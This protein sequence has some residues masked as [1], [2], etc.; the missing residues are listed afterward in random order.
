MGRKRGGAPKG[1][2]NSTAEHRIVSNQLMK[3]L[4]QDALKGKR[5]K[6]RK[7]LEK[8]LTL[9]EGGDR[10][11]LEFIAD[12]SEGKPTQPTQHTGNV[13]VTLSG[14]DADL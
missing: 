3:V 12:R 7:A 4:K 6:V 9:A 5:S 14:S 11:A 10:G 8:Q 13:T 1:N 2:Q